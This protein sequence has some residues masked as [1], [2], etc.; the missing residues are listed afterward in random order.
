LASDSKRTT[1]KSFGHDLAWATDS[2]THDICGGDFATEEHFVYV[3][4]HRRLLL[5]RGGGKGT[6]VVQLERVAH[7]AVRRF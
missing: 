4:H 2:K 6:T 3:V 5:V 7:Y 1:L